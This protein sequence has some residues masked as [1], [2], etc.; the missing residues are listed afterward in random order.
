MAKRKSNVIDEPANTGDEASSRVEG[1]PETATAEN[2]D[3]TTEA[4]VATEDCGTE[5]PFEYSDEAQHAVADDGPSEAGG[6]LHD[7]D[8][9]GSGEQSAKGYTVKMPSA[10][11]MEALKNRRAAAAARAAAIRAEEQNKLEAAQ[12]QA[13]AAAAEKGA[14]QR[15]IMKSIRAVDEEGEEEA[16]KATSGIPGSTTDPVLAKLNR[17]HAEIKAVVPPETRPM[18]VQEFAIAMGYHHY[19]KRYYTVFGQG[20]QLAAHGAARRGSVPRMGSRDVEEG[21]EEGA[22]A[23]LTTVG[24]KAGAIGYAAFRNEREGAPAVRGRG[25]AGK[26]A[27]VS[28]TGTARAGGGAGGAV[29]AV[30]QKTVPQ[31][32]TKKEDFAVKSFAEI[33]KAK[34][35]A[36]GNGES[37]LEDVLAELGESAVPVTEVIVASKKVTPAPAKKPAGVKATIKKAATA[38]KAAAKAPA[39]KVRSLLGGALAQVAGAAGGGRRRGAAGGGRGKGRVAKRLG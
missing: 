1:E 18:S 29:K 25:T 3:S 37:K 28:A 12:A 19:L 8:A 27:A 39:K 11:Q 15:M 13:Q 7:H 24:R 36:G 20:S 14:S 9:S 34:H 17:L 4:T 30:P 2:T 10:D 32:A 33:M 22:E 26:S 23:G 35:A 5:S 21:D 31:A 38:P 16:A 6:S